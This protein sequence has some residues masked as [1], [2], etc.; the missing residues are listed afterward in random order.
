MQSTIARPQPIKT[1][2]K[3]KLATMAMDPNNSTPPND[4][5]NDLKNRMSVYY[6]TKNYEEDI[7]LDKCT[8][9]KESK[10]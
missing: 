3:T 4:F 5:I 9:K 1:F 10:C 2:I 8:A 7:H 6:S